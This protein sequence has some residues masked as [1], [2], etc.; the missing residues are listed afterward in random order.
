MPH[1]H[2]IGTFAGPLNSFS[3]EESIGDPSVACSARFRAEVIF[4][5]HVHVLQGSDTPTLIFSL[6][7]KDTPFSAPGV[8]DFEVLPS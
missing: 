3:V 6:P 1:R 7:K 4:V 2:W 5:E 8:D